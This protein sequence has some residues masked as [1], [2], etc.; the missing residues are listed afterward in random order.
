MPGDPWPSV[1]FKN[2]ALKKLTLREDY[3][4]MGRA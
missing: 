4:F 3:I 1:V 2:E